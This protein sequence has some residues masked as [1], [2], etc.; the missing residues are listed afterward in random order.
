[1]FG[2]DWMRLIYLTLLMV[3]IA[4]GLLAEFAGRR[5]QALRQMAAWAMIFGVVIA[6]ALWWEGRQGARQTV[7]DGRRIEVP[8]SGDG[9][10][11]LT[12]QLNGVD[13]PFVVDTGATEVALSQDDAQRIGL[14]PA[15]LAYMGRANTANGQIRTA[16]VTIGE[17]RIGDI[18]DRNVG[19]SVSESDMGISLLG[20][21]YLRRFARVGFE[22]D[23]LILER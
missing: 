1:M 12:A 23:L 9:H 5:N 8:M 19:A 10:F 21:S 17:F 3:S 6:A 4:G 20:M 15:R 16:P 18:V 13:V 2:D 14:D 22:G 11:Y 7:F